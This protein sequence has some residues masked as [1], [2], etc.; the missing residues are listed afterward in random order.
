MP[1]E[2]LRPAV[3][4]LP[5]EIHRL[6]RIAAAEEDLTMDSLLRQLVERYLKTRKTTPETSR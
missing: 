2:P 3:T 5:P 6:L 4:K 1:K